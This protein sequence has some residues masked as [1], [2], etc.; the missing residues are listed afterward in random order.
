L[1]VL[2]SDGHIN[3]ESSITSDVIGHMSES[4]VEETL[5]R[6]KALKSISEEGQ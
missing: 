3:Y 1:A 2:D 4:D 5:N 6:I